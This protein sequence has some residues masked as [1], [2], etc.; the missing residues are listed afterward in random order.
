[1]YA[2]HRV[3]TCQ[4]H[5]EKGR[6]EG[7]GGREGGREGWREGER[8][9]CPWQRVMRRVTIA[10]GNGELQRA[11]HRQEAASLATAARAGSPTESKV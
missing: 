9:S 11:V 10:H 7:E 1:M 6:G 3:R 2:L 4:D 5:R 8:E